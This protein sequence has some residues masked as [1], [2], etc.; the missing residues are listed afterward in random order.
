MKFLHLLRSKRENAFNTIQGYNDIKNIVNRVLDAE[1]NY[2]LLFIGAPAS[3]KTL[4]LQGILDIKKDGVFFDGSNTTSRILD[5]LEE[6]R[7][8][9][10][11]LDEIDKLPRNFQ[12]KLLMFLEN[13]RI[14]VDQVKRSYDFT[15]PGA[16]LFATAND[17]NS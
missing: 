1:D 13:G 8:K 9:I 11:C 2:N 5:V 4:F 7:P 10:I 14:K 12:E 6:Q 16:K 3:S 17:I 15:I